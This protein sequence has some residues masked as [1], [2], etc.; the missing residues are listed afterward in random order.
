MWNQEEL[1]EFKKL[2]DLLIAPFHNDM[3][4]TGTPTHIW[5]VVV[6]NGLFVRAYNGQESSWYQAAVRNG[7]GKISI[8]GKEYD[9]EFMHVDDKNKLKEVD[10]AYMAKYA[11]SPYLPDMTEDRARNA[12]IQIMTKEN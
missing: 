9:V 7:Q 2:D 8:G 6:E 4:T 11:G 10:D 12:T 1:F 3:K 5:N